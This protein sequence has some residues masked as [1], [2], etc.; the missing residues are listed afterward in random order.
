MSAILCG[1]RADEDQVRSVLTPPATRSYM[2]VP[3]GSIIDSLKERVELHTPWKISSAEYSLGRKGEQLFGVMNLEQKPPVIYAE[4]SW[5]TKTLQRIDPF[6][7][8]LRPSIGFRS[9]HDKSISIGIACGASVFVCDNMMFHSNGFTAIRKHTVNV[10][11]DLDRLVTEAL[12]SSS[13]NFRSMQ[14]DRIAMRQVP[15]D[16]DMG[17]KILGTAYGHKV[18]TAQQFTKA[19]KEWQESS[20]EVFAEED[21]WSLYNA[22]TFGMKSG[23]TGRVIDRYINAHE[24]FIG[25]ISLPERSELNE[26]EQV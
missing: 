3:Y 5:G 23:A 11:D 9:S 10:F 14:N 6:D 4:E 18:I 20:F 24:W 15:V 12:Q 7:D 25:Q 13:D 22:I 16:R 26:Q 17:Y 2:P 8:E 1:V 19:M 21:A